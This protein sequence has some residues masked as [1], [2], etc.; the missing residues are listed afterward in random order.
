MSSNLGANGRRFSDAE[1]RIQ[2]VQVRRQS[3]ERDSWF[4][5][6]YLFMIQ[7]REQQVLKLFKRYGF[8]RLEDKQILDV[9]CGIG[10][11]IN[12]LV[13]WGARPEN[14]IGVELTPERLV[15]A[16]QRCP[17]GIR[18]ISGNAATTEFPDATFDMVVQSTVFTTILEDDLKAAV[19]AEMLRVLKPHGLILWYDFMYNNPKNPDVRGV[20]KSEIYRL[21]PECRIDIQRLTLVPPLS[22]W[23]APY[24]VLLC[25]LLSLI[26]FLRT[27]YLGAIRKS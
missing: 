2:D 16:R 4:N 12:D 1:E 13:K 25:H 17:S 10:L 6:G 24:S 21:F 15:F 22:R 3:G 8:E 23:L 18:L 19:A 9:G 27:H 7:E 20:T 11:W 5:P 14:I 26:P